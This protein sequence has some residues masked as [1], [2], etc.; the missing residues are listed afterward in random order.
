MEPGWLHADKADPTR[1]FPIAAVAESRFWAPHQTPML[2][3]T[4]AAHVPF[5]GMHYAHGISVNTGF[6]WWGFGSFDAVLRLGSNDSASIPWLRQHWGIVQPLRRVTRGPLSPDRRLRR[7]ARP[8]YTFW[9]ADWAAIVS[10][11]AAWPSFI[12]DCRLDYSH[13]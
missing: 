13:G 5:A 6:G 1:A 8:G 10:L 7:S 12:F 4:N 3:R 11:R 9:S 2:D